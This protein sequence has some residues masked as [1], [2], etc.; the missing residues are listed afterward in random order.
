MRRLAALLCALVAVGTPAAYAGEDD[1]PA[2]V[3]AVRGTNPSYAT[4]ASYLEAAAAAHDVPPQVVKAVAFRESGWQPFQPTGKP[5][6]SS[7]DVCGIGLM[8]ITLGSR[9][10]G[11]ELARDPAYNAREGAKILAAKWA[12]LQDQAHP[13]PAGEGYGPDD[14]HVLEN[15][16]AVLC[17]YNGC[18]GANADLAYAEPVARL[19]HDPFQQGVPSAVVA[20]MPPAGFT[21]PRDADPEYV[22]PGGFQA[23]ADDEFHFFDGT[24]GAVTKIVTA[25]THTDGPF[26][27]YGIAYGPGGPNVSCSGCQW[28]RPAEGFGLAGWAHWTN[29]VSP[30]E[31]SGVYV[32]WTPP[33]PGT[34]DVRAWI[35]SL[36][37]EP[38]AP[39]ATYRIGSAAVTI[40]QNA[41][42]DVWAY[43]GKH[44]LSGPVRLGDGSTVG[45]VKIVADGLRFT[46]YT[47]LAIAAAS[48]VTYGGAVTVTARLSQ[49]GSGL[50]LPGHAVKLWQRKATSSA[51][52][53]VGTY[54]TDANGRVAVRTTPA[55]TTYYKATFASDGVA[56]A[57][58]DAIRRVDVKQKVTAALSRTTVPRN[59]KL[60]IYT[61][62]APAHAGQ[63]V[64]LQRYYS[65][66]WRNVSSAP[67]SSSS[68]AAF[69]VSRSAAGTYHYR[70]YK[71][72]DADHAAGYSPTQT[73]RVT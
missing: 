30:G 21:T 25:P 56:Y 62:V 10:D 71:P 1:C 27:G 28:W 9:T 17:R 66:A 26:P 19:I 49:Q 38:L 40:D 36:G 37:A 60:T 31:S 5:K 45:G 13:Y 59:T 8:Q 39:A 46:A 43:L 57:A 51:W 16:Y 35:P 18:L 53:L 12:E 34:Y 15:W 52:S 68:T 70:T 20:H 6:I 33:R 44:T 55:A 14:R 11:V 4:I 54:T 22:F 3:V 24:T 58:A 61:R 67:L 50:S 69:A 23:Q 63:R 7:D 2:D 72:A 42:K 47:N 65:G 48:S 73:F 64:Y 32:A 29:S 41:S